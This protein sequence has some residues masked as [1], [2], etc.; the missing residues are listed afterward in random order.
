[1]KRFPVLI[2]V[3]VVTALACAAVWAVVDETKAEGRKFWRLDFKH[4]GLHYVRVGGQLVAY[5]TYRVVNTTG[6]DRKFFP[7]FQVET[8]TKQL[9]Y[10]MPNAAAL[11]AI[12][13]KHRTHFLD[14]GEMSGT[15]KAGETRVGAAIFHK[16]DPEADHVKLEITGVTDAYRYLDEKA[17]T[18]FQR[19]LYFVHWY[20]P[21]DA[22][23]RD[24]D[25]VETKA[26]GWIWR[27]TGTAGTAPVD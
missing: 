17:R 27:S 2:T 18:G 5:T 3:V 8:E 12:Q 25:R 7:I 9:T 13:G 11:R 26:D 16:L 19:R 1:M 22:V 24:T 23:D 15:I 6:A 14:I 4:T 21:G 20:R 10:A